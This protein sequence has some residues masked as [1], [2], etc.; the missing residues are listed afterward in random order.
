MSVEGI[1]DRIIADAEAEARE[2]ISGA[3]SEA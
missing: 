1:I 2:I 3:E